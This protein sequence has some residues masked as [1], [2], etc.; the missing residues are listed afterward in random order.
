VKIA[1]EAR[2]AAPPSVV[3]RFFRMLDHLRFISP[4]RR[5]EWCPRR[6]A[7]IEPGSE[8]DLRVAQ[9]RNRIT[10]RFRNVR[11]E[12]DRTIEDEFISWPLRGARHTQ[13]FES[14]DG[15]LSTKVESVTTWEPPWYLRKVL[16][17]HEGEQRTFFAERQENAKRIIEAVYARKGEDAFKEG[18]FADAQLIG[19]A[20]VVN[21]D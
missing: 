3:F 12:L 10:L 13:T 15:G 14:L 4:K 5:V 17:R 6:G 11:F 2:I 7:L 19:A 21:A 20:P 18:I 16:E 1:V 8:A 9:G